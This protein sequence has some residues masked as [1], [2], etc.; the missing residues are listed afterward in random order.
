[1][2]RCFPFNLLN[3]ALGLTR[4]PLLHYVLASLVCMLPGTLAFTWLA[5]A[6]REALGGHDA[7]VRYGLIG[8]AVLAA[9]AFLPRLFRRF[10]TGPSDRERQKLELHI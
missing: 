4:I 9:I 1:L 10:R 2:C 3:Y 8:I 7:A 6:G 5:Y